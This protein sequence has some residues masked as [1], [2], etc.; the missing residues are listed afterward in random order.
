MDP[1]DAAMTFELAVVLHRLGKTEAAGDL[2]VKVGAKSSP[3]C[4]QCMLVH[5]LACIFSLGV[6]LLLLLSESV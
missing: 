2:Y 3:P 1:S 5:R 6:L 4:T